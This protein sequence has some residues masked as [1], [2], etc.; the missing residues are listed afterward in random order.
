MQPVSRLTTAL[1]AAAAIAGLSA[2]NLA[3]Q[4]EY[5][6][7]WPKAKNAKAQ[8]MIEKGNEMF[9]EQNYAAAR[10]EYEAAAELILADGD[11][12]NTAMYRIAASYYHEGKPMT[13]AH[14]LDELAKEAAE[15]GDIVTQA[16]ALA[17]AAWIWGVRGAKID[18]D[19]RVEAVK[20]LLKSPYMPADVKTEI[21]S[22]RLGEATTLTEGPE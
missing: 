9:G 10:T 19:S 4:E 3:A 5:D 18:M 17:D 12:P 13:A 16:W 1:V 8:A 2:T 15:Y 6:A 11:F 14:H 7:T 20:K 21:M 22:K